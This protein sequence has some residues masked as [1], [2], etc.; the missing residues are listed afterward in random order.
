M[1]DPRKISNNTEELP[2]DQISE[3]PLL[4]A[5]TEAWKASMDAG[6]GGKVD[7]TDAPAALLPT[8][9]LV[10][11]SPN[12]E[13]GTV[14]LAGTFVCEAHRGEMRGRKVSEFFQPDDARAVLHS[15]RTCIETM[16]PSLARR[17]YVAID[18]RYWE[19][20]R[21]LLPEAVDGKPPR[22]FKAMDR[23]SLKQF[24]I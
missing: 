22:I 9:M 24:R 1:L 20:V 12:F 7:P 14:R 23:R 21:L 11:L 13:D 8:V 10:D 19:Y 3:Y 16:T 18:D 15:M 5:T 2:L 6:N 17:S 4:A